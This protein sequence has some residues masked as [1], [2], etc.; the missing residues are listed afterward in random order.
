MSDQ[1]VLHD[2]TRRMLADQID[3]GDPVLLTRWREASDRVFATAS[4]RPDAYQGATRLVGL[5]LRDLQLGQPDPAALAQRWQQ[6]EDLLRAVL[7]ALPAEDRLTAGLPLPADQVLG[8]A[9][10]TAHPAALERARCRARAA[11]LARARSVPGDASE[12][13]SGQ[14][15]STGGSTGGWIVDEQPGDWLVIEESGH[16]DG[17]PFVPYQRLEVDAS[18]GALLISTAPDES[19]TGCLHQVLAL[20]LDPGSGRLSE[21]VEGGFEITVVTAAERER[22]A[23]LLRTGADP[24]GRPI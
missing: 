20:R 7:G 23:W 5:L 1:T 18:G 3:K 4:G 21:P 11:V 9:F 17:D 15:G 22:R 24:A 19:M 2:T 14:G 16:Y 13:P 6:R 8:A 10:A 12:T